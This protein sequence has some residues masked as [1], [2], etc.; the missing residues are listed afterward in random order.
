MERIEK[1]PGEVGLST[2][3]AGNGRVFDH[4][5]V[6]MFE[7][8][9]R[10]YVRQNAYFARLAREGVDLAN[11]FGVMHPSQTNYIASIAGELC[12]V[13]DD[14]L[15]DRLPQET[16]VDVIESRG[17][18]WKAYMDG[19]CPQASQWSLG[20]VPRDEYPYVVKHNPF[21]AFARVLE[22]AD[23]WGRVC[24]LSQ[25]WTDVAAGELP[26]YAWLT[27]DMWNDGHYV[28]GTTSEPEARAPALVD[29][30]AQWLEWFFG[31]LRFPGAGSLLPPR[32]LVV[33]TFDESD[34]EAAYEEAEKYTYDGPNQI[35]CVLLGDVV[36]GG[37]V[38][39]EGYNH[40][41]L[42]RTVEENFGLAT[43]GKNDADASWFRFLW[44]ERFVWGEAV[45][46]PLPQ[47]ALAAAG[48]GETLHVV[49]ETGS[50][51]L[52]HRTWHGERWSP[53]AEVWPEARGPVVA[54]AGDVAFVAAHLPDGSLAG[55]PLEGRVLGRQVPL[56][57]RAEGAAIA[58]CDR[59]RGLMLV[60]AVPGGELWARRWR[61]G[62]WEDALPVG[63]S[64][65]GGF[66]LAALGHTFL[67]VVEHPGGHLR[68]ATYGTASFNA[69]TVGDSQYAGPYDDTTVDAWSPDAFPVAHFAAAA[70]KV[71][72]GEREPRLQPYAST[73]PL[74]AADLDGVIHLVHP[75]RSGEYLRHTT[76]SLAGIMTSKLP[77]SYNARDAT[78]TS[79]GYGTLAEAGWSTE[80][81]LRGAEWSGGGALALARVGKTVVLLAGG[82]AATRMVVGRYVAK[83]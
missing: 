82:G 23:R 47:A 62:R 1:R 53:E 3:G 38:E 26:E 46:T 45:E 48:V 44:D 20:L 11:A 80:R 21:A 55:A 36:R 81:A 16:I 43:L 25:L 51:G 49:Q 15:P 68:C 32:T 60:Y 30:A 37:S 12:N 59:G 70:S 73:G 61:G 66:T 24:S 69:V 8:Q 78:T 67:L 13:T 56:A 10:A 17:L 31:T 76:F 41:S 58:P 28:R 64:T 83:G 14:V 79:N 6:I 35:Y 72:P 18:R 54:A 2:S 22:R 65:A 71:T 29:Q 40:Y 57:P 77:V 50:G 75:R 19:Y 4:V 74:A 63:H 7:N 9:Y 39:R 33:V 5:L 52:V 34:F 42:L 27:P